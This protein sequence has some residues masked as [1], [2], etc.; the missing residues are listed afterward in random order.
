MNC[1]LLN[2]KKPAPYILTLF[3]AL[4][5]FAAQAEGSVK[6]GRA[7]AQMCEACHGLDGRSKMPEV[8]NLSGQVEGYINAQLTAF[9]SGERKNEQMSVIAQSLSPEDIQN[10]ASY[11]SKIEITVGKIPGN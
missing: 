8:P 11:Y 10:L 9:K 2:F 1:H 7:K 4:S 3:L 6:L 5:S